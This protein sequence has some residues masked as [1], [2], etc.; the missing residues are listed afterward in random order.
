MDAW[1][2]VVVVI[3]GVALGLFGNAAMERWRHSY[4][5]KD[6]RADRYAAT[7]REAQAAIGDFMLAWS[8]LIWQ[9]AQGNPADLLDP[10]NSGRAAM[11]R[12][13]GGFNTNTLAPTSAAAEATII[14]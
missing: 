5:R 4:I 9:A 2:G 1:I 3:A 13:A 14:W 11:R 8:P 6:A 7:L 10:A 12:P